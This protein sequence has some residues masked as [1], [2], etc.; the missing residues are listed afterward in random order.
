MTWLNEGGSRSRASVAVAANYLAGD[1][2]GCAGL[3]AFEAPFHFGNSGFRHICVLPK[4]YQESLLSSFVGIINEQ[5]L[6][7][8]HPIRVFFAIIY[9]MMRHLT[10]QNDFLVAEDG[11]FIL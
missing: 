10:A 5:A 11:E 1:V 6:H 8:P 4:K 9:L 7:L 2:K 3:L